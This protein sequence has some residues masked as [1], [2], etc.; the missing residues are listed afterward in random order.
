MVHSKTLKNKSGI[1]KNVQVAHRKAKET[2]GTNNKK[3]SRPLCPP[4]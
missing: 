3:Q 1:L 4:H 2:E